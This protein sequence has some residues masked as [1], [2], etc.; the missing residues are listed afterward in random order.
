M[1][2]MPPDHEHLP[3]GRPLTHHLSRPP[4][5]PP[6]P[7]RPSPHQPLP[8]AIHQRRLLPSGITLAFSTV[9]LGST[10]QSRKAHGPGCLARR[11]KAAAQGSSEGEVGLGGGGAALP[12][13]PRGAVFLEAPKAPEQI[14]DWPKARRKFWP[15]HLGGGGVGPPRMESCGVL[16]NSQAHV[17]TTKASS[18]VP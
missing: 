18:V 4:P 3:L 2:S 6:P 8:L 11:H 1:E 12:P 9:L 10:Q 16:V 7:P 17:S 15:N 14:F 13:P 5:P